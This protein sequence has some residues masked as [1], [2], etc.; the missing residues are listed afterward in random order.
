MILITILGVC[1]ILLLSLGQRIRNKRKERFPKKP[2]FSWQ[3]DVRELHNAIIQDILTVQHSAQA[4][5]EDPRVIDDDFKGILES[6]VDFFRVDS[7][8]LL[9][10][11]V[12]KLPPGKEDALEEYHKGIHACE[13][14]FL[15][16]RKL[17][18]RRNVEDMPEQ[19]Q[20]FIDEFEEAGGLLD[21]AILPLL[22][23]PPAEA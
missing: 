8:K 5:I 3:E 17:L 18:E 11:D 10:Y 4:A 9:D 7:K 19:L 14:C 13:A 21:V 2:E 16:L 15:N 6:Q 12:Y 1:I 23:D 22:A 20:K